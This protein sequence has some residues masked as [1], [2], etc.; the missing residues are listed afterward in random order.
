[1]V[2][3]LVAG[4]A[5]FLIVLIAAGAAIL[6]SIHPDE[7]INEHKD[8]ITAAVQ[9]NIG[10]DLTLG[11]IKS[12]LF[13]TLGAVISDSVLSG[14][15]EASGPQ[16]TLGKIEIKI[17]LLKAILSFGQVLEIETIRLHELDVDLARDKN[18][19]WNFQ[20]ILDHM[21]TRTP[22]EKTAEDS[23]SEAGPADLSFLEGAVISRIAIENARIRIDDKMLGQPLTISNLNIETTNIRL[24]SPI[25]LELNANLEDGNAKTPLYFKG[26]LAELR[27]DLS[28]DP[29]PDT[30]VTIRIQDFN[31][32]PW[33]ALLPRQDMAPYSGRMSVDVQAEAKRGLTQLDVNAALNLE[34][35]VLRQ[36]RERGKPLN[37]SVILKAS[38]DTNRPRYEIKQVKVDGTGVAIDGSLLAFGLSPAG[39]KKADIK[40]QVQDVERIVQVIPANSPL[41]PKELTLKGPVR[42]HVSG[43]VSEVDISLNLD[44]VL[45][46][47]AELFNKQRGRPLN[48]VLKGK[49]KGDRLDVPTFQLVVDAA[50]FKG[51]LT[52]PTDPKAPFSADVSSGPIP[53]RSLNRLL[54]PIEQALQKGDRVDGTIEVSARAKVTGTKQDASTE[55]K[56]TN[57]DL[58][59]ANLKA[60]GGGYLKA[61]VTP[62]D[63]TTTL[64]AN[65]DCGALQLNS[66]D[67]NGG[68]LLNKPAGMPLTLNVD[69]IH[70]PEKANVRTAKLLIGQT[71]LDVKGGASGLQ[72]DSPVLNLDFG[73]VDIDFDD[74][75]RTVPGASQL[76]SGGELKAILKVSGA[77]T[78]LSTMVVD[79]KKLRLAF[80]KT[81]VNGDVFV[82][83]L[84]S[85]TIDAS[86]P[87]VKVAFTDIQQFDDSLKDLPKNG[88]FD[89]ALEFKGNTGK[90]STL[91][92]NIKIA[93]L[94]YGKAKIKGNI[95]VKNLDRPNFFFDLQSPYLNIDELLGE[96]DEEQTAKQADDNESTSANP[97]GLEAEVRRQIA[98]VSGTGKLN[99][100][101][102]VFQDMV[103]KNFKGHLKMKH[104][105][106]TFDALD[107]DIY[108]GRISAAGSSFDLPARYTG[109]N[110]KLAVQDLQIGQA[111]KAH[112]SMGQVMTGALNQKL[113]VSGRGLSGKDLRKSLDGSV[114]FTTKSL[115]IKSLDLLGPIGRPVE[116]ALK[117][118]GNLLGRFNGF[119]A[120]SGQT[121]GA[122]SS[123][124][125][126]T[127]KNVNA[128]LDFKDGQFYLQKPINAKTA[129]GGIDLRGGGDLDGSIDLKATTSLS[130]STINKALGRKAVSKDVTVPLHIG[131]T[132]DKPTITG[133]DAQ[134]LVKS[135]LGGQAAEAL[136]EL[137]K[138]AEA[139]AAKLKAQAEK[140]AKKIR[141]RAEREAKK[142]EEKARRE[143]E[144]AKAKAER[145]A[146]KAKKAAEREAKKAQE[147]AKREAERA[148]KKA[149]RE[150]QKAKKKAEREAEK[151]RK[152]AE[153]EAEKAKKKAER[154]A[155]K[156]KEE[157]EDKAKDAINDLG[158]SLGF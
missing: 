155:K 133:V 77:P 44:D 131:G 39:L 70:T 124:K 52:L 139:E 49:Q 68:V 64:V 128:F 126:T 37:T 147:K 12:S 51:N 66:V 28:F 125:G 1:M 148:R 88:R 117:K 58:Q 105:V 29:V 92:A 40:L 113:N 134:S 150:A 10:R 110:L 2:K 48:L 109:Y 30:S 38:T 69:V 143:A 67:E 80:G 114:Q 17:A 76:P 4:I 104:G 152:K 31:V 71:R 149:E 111:L 56:L 142:A 55:I 25:E 118:S 14:N 157:A 61:A 79:A 101:T 57:L 90:L 27:K 78:S 121:Q 35:F 135:M 145:E 41:L 154:E 83:D 73:N 132:W 50:Q 93:E 24:G 156:L 102:A 144:K 74:I 107:F 129:F 81:Q 65:V 127:L 72:G 7:L 87:V 103:F 99:I 82:K 16:I 21:A 20:D 115:T 120:A 112:T 130:P 32:A 3:K 98:T 34:K 141:E 5:I 62:K 43:N 122:A 108:G 6:F 140:E 42:A 18:G 119:H 91:D 9:D 45:V 47:W 100:G 33:G 13:P 158:K 75:R 136:D 63:D 137:K 96:D 85:P 106:V 94:V 146:Q 19:L 11:K 8:E 15:E 53:F 59:L 36:G 153:R 151:A 116:Q 22:P 97:H 60:K 46:K 86:L 26:R 54:P 89:G 23:S 84:D 123:L 95:G 138:Q